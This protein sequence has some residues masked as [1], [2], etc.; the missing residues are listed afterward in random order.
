MQK[1]RWNTT[2]IQAGGSGSATDR[3]FTFTAPAKGIL[4]VTASNTGNSEDLAR[5]IAVVVGDAAPQS[6]AGGFAATS[7][8]VVEFEIEAG[9]VKIYPTKAL[10][11]YKIEFEGAGAA[12]A[13]EDHV[14][15]FSTSD[16]QSQLSPL[17]TAGT[18]ITT[19]WNI[20]VDGL[21]FYSVQKNR[22]NTTYI[23][24]GGS[25]SATDRVFTFTVAKA[26]ELTVTASN[27]GNSEDL[28][29]EI[30]VVVGEAAPQSKP[31]GFG[32]ATPG[33]VKFDIE[34]G[35]IKV[36]P[37]KALRIYKIEFHSK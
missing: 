16:W 23:Q 17:G 26:G 19:T 30:A 24:A 33:D 13:K 27:T 12:P 1:N 29:R 6:K 2:Y 36:Y 20:T 7:P 11:I 4:K 22:W 18:D 3:V 31:G 14:W 8:A 10:R 5:Q 35:D 9:E 37:T 21:T 32:A 25:G 34:A 15:D 28:A